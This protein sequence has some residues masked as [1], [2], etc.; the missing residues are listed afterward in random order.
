MV[1]KGAKRPD[2]FVVKMGGAPLMVFGRFVFSIM[3]KIFA[4]MANVACL[5]R[6]P[7]G[8]L[9]MFNLADRWVLRS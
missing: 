5:C 9:L 3:E 2:L 4:I 1:I 6:H 7:Q 8:F